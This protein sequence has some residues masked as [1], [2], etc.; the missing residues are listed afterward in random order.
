MAD[1]LLVG[2]D[3]DRAA[4][5]RSLLKKDGYHVV[6]VRAVQDWTRV[7]HEVRPELIVAAVGSPDHVL[8]VPF[9]P[10]RG[11]PAPL[12]LVQGESDMF[13]DVHREDRLVDRMQS[14]FMAEEFLGRVDALVR[15]RRV[16]R[17]TLP[18][19]APGREDE[20]ED[21]DAG[22][23]AHGLRGIR[24]RLG[25]LLTS[26]VPRFNRPNVP[27]IEVA[28]RVADWADRR[29]MFKPG[30]AERVTSFSAMIADGLDMP[31]SEAEVLLRAAMLHDIGKVTLP[32]E[33]LRQK[34]PLDDEKMRLVRTH[35]ER[36]ATLLRALD[37]DEEVAR[38]ILYHHERPDG[39]GYYGKR[40]ESV[41]RPARVLAVAEAYDAMTAARWREPVQSQAAL[42]ML[43][44]RRGEQFD[45]ESV[46]ALVD[47]LRPRPTTCI[48]LKETK[49]ELVGPSR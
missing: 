1:I 46:D 37:P 5:L 28:A 41:P 26:R 11:F 32:V 10:L 39:S 9:K 22:G 4:G 42:A 13:R 49:P 20:D 40:G 47:A 23:L 17:R 6:W 43:E 2:D 34:G 30:H 16:I 33:V 44:E 7:E 25:A 24:R 18:P 27:Y 19:R 14:P 15:V 35:A 29:D 45:A 21:Q 3:R 36:G 48:P 38:V 8:S 12:L 31:D